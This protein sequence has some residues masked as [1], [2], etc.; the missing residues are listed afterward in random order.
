[1]RLR[2][3][4]ASSWARDVDRV[5]PVVIDPSYTYGVG[6]DTWVQGGLGPQ[7]SGTEL[8]VG[9]QDGGATVARSLLQ[10]P[11]GIPE[12]YTVSQA[13]L[14]LYNIQSPSCSPR[15]ADIHVV[16]QQSFWDANTTWNNQAGLD[17]NGPA[18]SSSFAKGGGAGCAAGWVEFD[19]SAAMRRLGSRFQLLAS[20]EADNQ[21]FRVFS[22]SRGAN[23]PVF[24]ITYGYPGILN[25]LS[26]RSEE[27]ITTTT[28]TLSVQSATALWFRIATG[29]DAESG[30]VI[31]SGWIAPAVIDWVNQ[32]RWTVPPGV[33]SDGVT[34]TWRVWKMGSSGEP[35]TAGPWVRTLPVD[36]RTGARTT[37]PFDEVGP[38][39]VNLSTGNAL[40]EVASPRF[41]TVGG[42]VGMGLSYNSMAAVPGGLTG[43]YYDDADGD[44][45]TGL[46]QQPAATRR[47]AQVS[48]DWGVQSPLPGV[49][50]PERFLA[51]WTGF[52][53]APVA[54]TYLFGAAAD[55][56][57]RVAINDQVVLDRWLD[58]PAGAPAYG[59]V[60]SLAAN[61]AVPITI[62][63]YNNTSPASMVLWVKGAVS[64]RIV[65]TSWLSVSAPAVP[66]GWS[67]V[68]GGG[69]LAYIRAEIQQGSVV[70]HT[71]SGVTRGFVFSAGGY[72][73]PPG[74]DGVLAH[75]D[76]GRLSLHGADGLIY[77]FD[78][79][80]NLVSATSAL[81]DSRPAAPAY[82]WAGNPPRLTAI[83][84][85][86]S[87]RSIA[88]RYAPD[89]ACPAP[90]A[91]FDAL[92]P[93]S[94]LCLVTYWDATA[95]KVFYV[96]GQLGRIEDPG[97]AVT[98]LGYSAGRLN[99]LRSPLATDAIAAGVRA[100]DATAA[101]ALAYDAA[102]RV[103]TVTLPAPLAGAALPAHSY[104]YGLSPSG[105]DRIVGF[106]QV[107]VAG[108]PE[109][110]G[111]ARRVGFDA[112]GRLL[113]DYDP[114]A[115]RTARTW[116]I[117]D[118]PATENSPAGTKRWSYD[119]SGRQ[120]GTVTSET[121]STSHR[122]DE[123]MAGLAATYWNNTAMAGKP[124]ARRLGIG[125]AGGAVSAD[126]GTTGVPVP[127]LPPGGWS[128]RLTGDLEAT[129][130]E[131]VGFACRSTAGPG[132]TSTAHWSSTP[133][134]TR[135]A[136]PTPTSTPCRKTKRSASAWRSPSRAFA[137]TTVPTPAGP[138]WNL[139][140]ITSRLPRRS[141]FPVAG[142]A[143]AT[144]WR[145]PPG[146]RR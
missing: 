8:R 87:E 104:E 78:A 133:G 36:L 118:Q 138:A 98:D 89:P 64:E 43:A 3:S 5:F 1:M 135:P 26:P 121:G 12:G 37:N 97:G 67:L 33:L 108:Q 57:V 39:K 69:G 111:Y 137:S 146:P 84:D 116:T 85:P 2:F 6:S 115:R 46:G 136:S 109:P 29:P 35:P 114:R 18:A 44:R 79:A 59:S 14:S 63:Y 132:F 117:A 122:Y 41:G 60:V 50:A 30:A 80:G 93:A 55:D 113:S 123:A 52:V 91:G 27:P 17:G 32:A 81:D 51:R 23:P 20:D 140:R 88:L 19:V 144:T 102:G 112:Q 106:T 48:F 76:S 96:D 139:G 143:P 49:L 128:V 22:S 101:T 99:S 56:G 40:V 34:Y 70:L 62:D 13:T 73:S 131:E 86:V 103:A 83:T 92:P 21:S 94:M 110:S 4:V 75:D 47:D 16:G 95:T 74:E 25:V 66:Q 124:F 54:G 72:V 9:T 38:V 28:P 100:N 61:A 45:I 105:G 24:T 77:V 53:S 134:M 127:G 65:P 82:A 145:R 7:G 10:V 129:Y 119:R 58:Q 15:R 130:A 42:D 90:P 125:Q 107:H 11:G 142:S 141:S 126:W 71:P 68:A 31:N 120:A